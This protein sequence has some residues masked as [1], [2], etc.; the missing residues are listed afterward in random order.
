MNPK[1]SLKILLIEQAVI[2][3]VI[4][5]Y[6]AYK[7]H[8]LI[9]SSQLNENIM[10]HRKPL[11]LSCF[12][13]CFSLQSSPSP[14]SGPSSLP[15]SS[16]APILFLRPHPPLM[17]PSSSYAPSSCS[18]PILLLCSSLFS[19]SFSPLW[20]PFRVSAL[21]LLYCLNTNESTVFI[22]T[23]SISMDSSFFPSVCPAVCQSRF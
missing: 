20:G 17:P 4:N 18:T 13:Y 21:T 23:F 16:Y 1:S 10:R 19:C 22:H 15:F 7:T 12:S 14:I 11:I 3:A 2:V 8:R 6:E 9:N 5:P